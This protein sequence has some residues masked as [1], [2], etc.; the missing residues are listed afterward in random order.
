LILGAGLPRERT[1][2]CDH[3]NRQKSRDDFAHS[4]VSLP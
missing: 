1:K 4:S 2:P 3:N